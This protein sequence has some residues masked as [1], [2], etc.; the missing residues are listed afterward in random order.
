MQFPL[1]HARVTQSPRSQ[2]GKSRGHRKAWHVTDCVSSTP[3][4]TSTKCFCGRQS[5]PPQLDAPEHHT[6]G[7]AGEYPLSKEF[8]HVS[9]SCIESQLPTVTAKHTASSQ[10]TLDTPLLSQR[11]QIELT[12]SPCKSWQCVME[13]GAESQHQSPFTE[14]SCLPSWLHWQGGAWHCEPDHMHRSDGQA[15]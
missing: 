2:T 6:H 1:P 5:F 9:L 10:F 15:P 14:F 8:K 12:T 11:A 7:E 13:R 4:L 3:P